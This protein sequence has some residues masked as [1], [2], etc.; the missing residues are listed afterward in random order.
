MT[1]RATLTSAL[2]V[3][4]LGACTS[5]VVDSNTSS[6]DDLLDFPGQNTGK[7]DVFGRALVGPA[8]PYLADPELATREAR[9]RADIRFRRQAGWEIAQ[10]ALEPVPLLGLNGNATANNDG[11]VEIEG[12]MPTVPRW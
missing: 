11:P 2:L 5:A 3:I 8:A 12:G 6:V 7:A 9:L 10:R 1:L 4:L